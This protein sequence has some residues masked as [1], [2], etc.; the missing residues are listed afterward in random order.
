MF[1]HPDLETFYLQS[2]FFWNII[3]DDLIQMSNLEALLNSTLRLYMVF[4][5]YS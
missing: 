2:K 5:S 3:L 4:M 1:L